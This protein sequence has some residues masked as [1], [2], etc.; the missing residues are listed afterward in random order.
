[1]R[2]MQL[3]KFQTVYFTFTALNV[4]GLV[5]LLALSMASAGLI[6]ELVRQPALEYTT[7]A[8]QD[9]DALFSWSKSV[10]GKASLGY[11][12]RGP[13]D[14]PSRKFANGVV[15]RLQPAKRIDFY[16]GK[17]EDAVSTLL[18]YA[19]LLSFLFPSIAFGFLLFNL[20]RILKGIMRDGVFFSPAYG[21]RMGWVMAVMAAGPV[22]DYVL[23]YL[24]KPVF[25]R[26]LGVPSAHLGSDIGFSLMLHVPIL[27]LLATITVFMRYG[28]FLKEQKE[29]TV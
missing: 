19:L 4:L 2:N 21:R 12:F 28:A 11:K 22:A 26:I 9:C 1:M 3:S 13:E 10:R 14:T 6:V 15:M 7:L 24:L 25:G 20:Q 23:M 29:L 16:L 17:Q 27:L 8:A 18:E 5:S